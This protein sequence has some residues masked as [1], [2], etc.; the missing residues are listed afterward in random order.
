MPELKLTDVIAEVSA[1]E[2][3]VV[4]AVE[5]EVTSDKIK[6]AY[7]Y[8]Q[9]V[10]ASVIPNDKAQYAGLSFAQI[11]AKVGLTEAQVSDLYGQYVVALSPADATT[12]APAMEEIKTNEPLA[13]EPVN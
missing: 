11:G 5:P 3:T 9:W 2:Q 4:E 12:V 10:G 13:E 6:A 8:L 7:P 1:P